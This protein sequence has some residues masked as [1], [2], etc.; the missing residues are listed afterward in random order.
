[1]LVR[2]FTC[3]GRSSDISSKF[4]WVFSSHLALFLVKPLPKSSIVKSPPCVNTEDNMSRG[5]FFR[6]SP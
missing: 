1:M 3:L 6:I 4:F 2:W 5:V